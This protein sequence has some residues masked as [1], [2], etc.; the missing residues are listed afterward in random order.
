VSERYPDL[1]QAA[2]SRA[3]SS[4]TSDASRPK[5]ARRRSSRRSREP[6]PAKRSCPKLIRFTSDELDIV[7]ARA[8]EC[9]RPVAC[10]IRE[11]SLG[12]AP[13]ARA[14]RDDLLVRRLATLGNHLRALARTAAERQLPETS[15]FDAAVVELL[16]TI[17]QLD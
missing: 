3:D 17:S 16:D 1:F 5:P 14:A 11:A 12:I 6:Q 8:E 13:R 9:H 4:S 10:Y 7:N 15:A 2:T